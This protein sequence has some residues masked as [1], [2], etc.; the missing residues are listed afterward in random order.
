MSA[1]YSQMI[2][3]KYINT[4]TWFLFINTHTHAEGGEEMIES[5]Y[6]NMLTIWVPG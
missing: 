5:K 1:I 2:W 3:E 6:G 4:H